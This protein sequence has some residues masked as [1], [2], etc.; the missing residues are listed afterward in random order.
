MIPSFEEFMLPIL[1]VL[2]DGNA[3]SLQDIRNA[4]IKAFGFSDEE[5]KEELPSGRTTKVIDHITWALTYLR[6]AGLII[7]PSKG[8]SQIT[9]D[10]KSLLDNPPAVLNRKYLK[11]NYE[12]FQNF[13]KR[14][15]R[16]R[17]I[18]KIDDTKPK[19]EKSN[20]SKSSTSE[21]LK[22]LGELK[23]A[24]VLFKR[25]GTEPSK[26]QLKKVAELEEKLIKQLL[27]PKIA[28]QFTSD[29]DNISDN[30]VLFI[31]RERGTIAFKYDNS[32]DAL[33]K[34][35]SDAELFTEDSIEQKALRK[36]RPNWNFY[37]LGM[38]SGDEIEFI[39][40]SSQKATIVSPKSIMYGKTIY[41]SLEELTQLLTNSDKRVDVMTLWS[42]EGKKLIDIYNEVFPKD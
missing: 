13:T 23:S 27:F 9:D 33:E 36:R 10:G 31:K 3:Y 15:Q 7:N 30:F 16:K 21:L 29:L 8:I 41:P 40:D 24:I 2:S 28:K 37:N 32:I 4:T 20:S 1:M 22:S 39:L 18:Q 42:F 34:F 11:N 26:S 12:A 17:K 35:P 6:Q 19:I 5:I 14:S 38:I 25:M